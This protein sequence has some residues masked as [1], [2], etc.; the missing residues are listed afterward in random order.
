MIHTQH[1]LNNLNLIYRIFRKFLISIEELNMFHRKG[2]E[3]LK[4]SK[5]KKYLGCVYTYLLTG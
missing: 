3:N 1:N 5:R 2:I 4:V